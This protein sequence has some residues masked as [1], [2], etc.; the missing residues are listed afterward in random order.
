MPELSHEERTERHRSID[1]ARGS[2]QLSGGEL[3]SEVEALNAR[4]IAGELSG[5]EHVK[6]VIAHARTLP[7]GEPRQ[8][9]FTGLED[10]AKANAGR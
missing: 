6:A 10:T 4:Y 2:I 1:F 3:H 9:Y 5:N 7:K 8:V